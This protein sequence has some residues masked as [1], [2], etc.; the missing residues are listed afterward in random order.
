M[1]ITIKRAHIVYDVFLQNVTKILNFRK[2][3]LILMMSTELMTMFVFQLNFDRY[4]NVFYLSQ[5][6][7]TC[8][9][10]RSRIHVIIREKIDL[11]ECSF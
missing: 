3:M 2:I 7:F 10:L 8:V 4:R 1:T 6:N 11:V 9:A 5:F